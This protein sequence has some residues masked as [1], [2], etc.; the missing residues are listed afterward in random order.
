MTW[1]G[2][3]V[4]Y[5]QAKISTSSPSRVAAALNNYKKKER[6]PRRYSNGYRR[7]GLSTGVFVE[8]S[9]SSAHNLPTN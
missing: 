8:N 2:E 3:G 5:N 6:S 7:G 4:R 9:F 1:E